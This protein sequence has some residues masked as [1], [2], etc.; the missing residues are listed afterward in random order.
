MSDIELVAYT[1]TGTAFVKMEDGGMHCFQPG[2]YDELVPDDGLVFLSELE[3]GTLI[4]PEEVSKRFSDLTAVTTFLKTKCQF[5]NEEDVAAARSLVAQMPDSWID[6]CINTIELRS[7][8]LMPG[9]QR[10]AQILNKEIAHL[11]TLSRVTIQGMWRER[12][13]NAKTQV[14]R[15]LD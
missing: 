13:C 12:L 6:Y 15:F 10:K 7:Q 2:T 4:Q 14:A 8:A 9:E 5:T 11:L 1:Q 3:Q